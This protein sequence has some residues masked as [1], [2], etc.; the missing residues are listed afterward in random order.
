MENILNTLIIL[1][2]LPVTILAGDRITGKNFATRSEVIA[3]NGMAATSQPLATQ[4]AIDILK[5]GGTAVDAAIAANAALGLMEPT[6]SGIGGD[7]FAIVWDAKT[8]R[9][10][11]LNA[12]GRSPLALTRQ[13]FIEHG[14]EGIPDFGPLSVSVP[15][16]VD[17]WYE[18]HERFGRLPMK[19]ILAPAIGY[20]REG[21]PLSEL[22]AHYW[23]LGGERL[24]DYPG[25]A[26]TFLPEG[27]KPADAGGEVALV[28]DPVE[29]AWTVDPGVAGASV[30]LNGQPA[31]RAPVELQLDLC[32]QNRLEVSED[33]FRPAVIEIEPCKLEV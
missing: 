10:Y 7:L 14:H 31:G 33:G 4:T 23:K 5:A 16:C 1:I 24:K 11:G 19:D 27:G 8:R 15:G 26:E 9:L 6:G 28:L 12:S 25:F 22:I 29:L 21:F 32:R 30:S 3:R 20:A 18:L 13:Y 2:L 17:G